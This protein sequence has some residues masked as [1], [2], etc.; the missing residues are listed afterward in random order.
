MIEKAWVSFCISTYKRRELL[1]QQLTSLLKQTFPQFHIVVSDNDP[2]AS[3]QT[4]C[5]LVNDTRIKYFHNGEN[6]GMIRSF[7]KS[8]E[9]TTTDYIVMVTDD[10]PVDINFLNDFNRLYKQY[11]QYS[12]YCGFIRKNTKPDNL[13]FITNEEFITEILDP[14]KTSKILWSSCVIKKA[15]AIAINNIPDYGSPHLADHAFIA[16]V[17]NVH[18]GVVMNRMYSSLTSHNTNFSKSHFESYLSGCNGFY[19]TFF[20]LSDNSRNQILKAVSKH[21]K[22]WFISCFFALKK[23]YTVTKHDAVLLNEVNKFAEEIL[24]LSFMKKFILK[25]RLKNFI[26]QIK[27]KAGLLT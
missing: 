11:P 16:L 24:K 5:E 1:Q 22:F 13:E 20:K 17:G 25:F 23:Y 2:Q 21:L 3:A 9:R 12:I 10:D 27:Q 26:F 7:N 6:L 15:D 14:V 18:G 4:V 19:K 8:I